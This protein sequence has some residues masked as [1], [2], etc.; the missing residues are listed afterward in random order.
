MKNDFVSKGIIGHKMWSANCVCYG[1]KSSIF[2]KIDDLFLSGSKP[3]E[4]LIKFQ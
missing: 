2:D 3:Q 4:P 1:L